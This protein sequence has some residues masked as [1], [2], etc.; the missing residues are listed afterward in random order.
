MGREYVRD[1]KIVSQI[2]FAVD[3]VFVD[4]FDNLASWVNTG[5]TAGS[6]IRLITDDG[7]GDDSSIELAT[8]DA[9]AAD[10]DKVQALRIVGIDSSK[11]IRAGMV[12]RIAQASGDLPLIELRLLITDEINK[13][14]IRPGIRYDAE[15]GKVFVQTGNDV[16][17][18]VGDTEL[19]FEDTWLRLEMVIDFDA[20]EYVEQRIHRSIFQNTATPHTITTPTVFTDYVYIKAETQA[21]FKIRTLVSRV[22]VVGEE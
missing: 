11:K 16:W 1:T 19:A 18:E 8:R 20:N 9:S 12:C 3:P 21:A 13:R 2:G 7:F 17:T 14:E 15:T 22:W 5:S 6:E 10:G 4:N